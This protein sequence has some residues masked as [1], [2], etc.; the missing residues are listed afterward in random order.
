MKNQPTQPM[1]NKT[2][3]TDFKNEKQKQ[4]VSK[5]GCSCCEDAKPITLRRKKSSF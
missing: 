3:P 4:P 1:K 2:K 5:K